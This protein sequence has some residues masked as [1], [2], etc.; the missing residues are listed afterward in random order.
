MNKIRKIIVRLKRLWGLSL[1]YD[2]N[3]QRLDEAIQYAHERIGRTLTVHG[4]IHHKVPSHIIVIGQYHNRD[5]VRIFDLDTPAF[6]ELVDMLKQIEPY[7]RVGR[8]DTL[9]HIPFDAVYNRDIFA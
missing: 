6:G 4:D 8:F 9:M 5:Y 3:T 7:G 2:K 1:E